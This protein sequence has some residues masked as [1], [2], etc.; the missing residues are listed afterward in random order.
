MDKCALQ[1]EGQ[2]LV[3]GGGDAGIFE[4][5][6]RISSRLAEHELIVLGFGRLMILTPPD[7]LI[8]HKLLLFQG[9]ADL[10]L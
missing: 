10:A 4:F 1:M 6:L 9:E 5:L 3:D 7:F 2:G 8:V